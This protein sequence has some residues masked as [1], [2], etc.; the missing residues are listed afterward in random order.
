MV[1][2]EV[3]KMFLHLGPGVGLRGKLVQSNIC[4]A[5]YRKKNYDNIGLFSTTGQLLV[6]W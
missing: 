2:P 5:K 1:L 3:L 6:G 4:H